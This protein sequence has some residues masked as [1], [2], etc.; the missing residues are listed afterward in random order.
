L[1][2]LS[3]SS[4]ENAENALIFGAGPIGLLLGVGMKVAGI[5]DISFV[6]LEPARL[7]FAESFGFKPISGRRG[8]DCQLHC[9]R[10]HWTFFWSLS[11]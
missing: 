8:R 10:G 5:A 4:A 3:A 7:E 2:G 1:N 6:D 11:F 9:E